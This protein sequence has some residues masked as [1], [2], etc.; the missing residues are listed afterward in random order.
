M[1]KRACAVGA[2][3]RFETQLVKIA[4][5]TDDRS[6]ASSEAEQWAAR[7]CSRKRVREK[8]YI[9]RERERERET[10]RETERDRESCQR[11]KIWEDVELR[12]REYLDEN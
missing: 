10:E 4:V 8:I 2:L 7:L 9:E 5:R 3:L 6:R 12:A 11:E 1:S